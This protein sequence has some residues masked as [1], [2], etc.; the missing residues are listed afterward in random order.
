MI[1]SSG[2]DDI[3]REAAR[4]A[5]REELLN[6]KYRDAQPPLVVRL[7]GRLIRKFLE[8]LDRASGGVPGGRLGLLLILLLVAAFVAVVLVRLR[9]TRRRPTSAEVFTSG[10]ALTAEQHRALA[11]EAAATG[12]WAEAVR[13]RLRAIVRELEGRGV[14]EPRPGRTAGEV[15]RDGSAAV[16]AIAQPLAQATSTF[17]RIWYGGRIADASA[18]DVLVAA[19][20]AVTSARLAPA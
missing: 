15:A 14:L 1:L 3:T 16:P 2:V 7:I 4:R 9:P 19:D 13:E 6:R 18:Y 20:R 17:D 5:A 11:D 10:R 12:Q 8:L